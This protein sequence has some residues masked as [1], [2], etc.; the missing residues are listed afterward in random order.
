[1]LLLAASLNEPSA[2]PA[3]GHAPHVED[4]PAEAVFAGPEHVPRRHGTRHVGGGH[5][6]RAVGAA[7]LERCEQ[8]ASGVVEGALPAAV[9]VPDHMRR[10]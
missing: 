5:A 1:V 6:L 7:P 4:R 3:H 9:W 2:S 10:L 8:L